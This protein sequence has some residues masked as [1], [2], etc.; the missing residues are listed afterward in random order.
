MPLQESN[1]EEFVTYTQTLRAAKDQYTARKVQ[2]DRIKHV[3]WFNTVLS[4]KDMVLLYK[5]GA[6]GIQQVIASKNCSGA[7][8]LPEVPTTIENV[9]GEDVEEI[10]HVT[11]YTKPDGNIKLIHV[12]D[13]VSW[14]VTNTLLNQ[15]D[16]KYK[17]NVRV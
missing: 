2:K 1:T 4:A 11:F 6:N 3:G 5:D 14:T 9:L 8:P 15:L 16:K 12:D 10:H 17:E 13:I 7:Q